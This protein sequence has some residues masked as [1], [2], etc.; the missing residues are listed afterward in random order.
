MARPGKGSP[1]WR[2]GATVTVATT[3][4]PCPCP[5]PGGM[6]DNR[7]AALFGERSCPCGDRCCAAGEGGYGGGGASAGG[8]LGGV[9]G[10]DG[11]EAVVEGRDALRMAEKD[12]AEGF[13]LAGQGI[14]PGDCVADHV[15]FGDT[16]E[17]A[18]LSL[19]GAGAAV[20]PVGEAGGEGVGDE[21]AVVAG[22]GGGALFERGDPA[23]LVV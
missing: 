18:G 3:G 22:D 12:V 19:L 17:R 20:G 21:D 13:V 1:R 23:D 6:A 14:L 4:L 7:G 16:A 5:C 15:A 9:G 2:L 10:Q 8:T 11:V